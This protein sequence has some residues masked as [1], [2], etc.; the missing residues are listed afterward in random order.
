MR[1]M[2][3]GRAVV[4]AAVVL[5]T[6]CG[7]ARDAEDRDAADD[8]STVGDMP[9][10]EVVTPIDS[11]VQPTDSGALVSPP[12]GQAAVDRSPGS[13]APPGGGRPAG[14][15][16]AE[17]AAP[18]AGEPSPPAGARQAP[19][20][21]TAAIL[22][23]TAE[24]YQGIRS[25]RA[26]FTMVVENPLLR[27]RNTSRGTLH[28]RQPDRLLLDFTEPAGDRIVSDG[29]YFWVY[30]P[31][32]SPDQVI[33]TP[34]SQA[35]TGGVDLQAQFVGDPTAKF[36]YTLEGSEAVGGRPAHVFTLVPRERTGY[37]ELKVWID[38]R[39]SLVRRFELTEPNG[40]VRRFEFS[41]I[42][43][44]PSLGDEL[45][46]FTPPPNVRVVTR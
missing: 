31:S 19:A 42:E 4:V 23:R 40:T 34:A 18:P 2:I 21:D 43:R 29:T 8:S 13:A 38:A 32:V 28:Q 41:S 14:G 39:D 1:I 33:R 17:P 26:D 27:S 11:P 24:V 5:A 9:A 12:G 20:Q 45:F 6:A 7:G 3:G 44:N 25:M 10:P 37:D 35:G 15:G 16:T 36:R 46:R 30:Y 22:K